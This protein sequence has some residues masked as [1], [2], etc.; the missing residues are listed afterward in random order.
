MVGA[1]TEGKVYSRDAALVANKDGGDLQFEEHKT[2]ARLLARHPP[3]GQ[4]DKDL[5]G[6]ALRPDARR[7]IAMQCLQWPEG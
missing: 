4:P 3:T 6:L 1:G 5:Y 2:L 7:A